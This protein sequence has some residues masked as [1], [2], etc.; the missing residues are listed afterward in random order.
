[1]VCSECKKHGKE[2][3]DHQKKSSK[4]CPYNEKNKKSLRSNT[5]LS[6]RINI[7][8]VDSIDKRKDF[9]LAILNV[10]NEIISDPSSL[11]K[12]DSKMNSFL[13]SQG[14]VSAQG[15]GNQVTSQEGSFALLLEKYNFIFIPKPKKNDHIS[16]IESN[17]IKDG[18]YYVYQFNGTQASIDFAIFLVINK[19]IIEQFEFDLKHTSTDIFYL[20]DGW[21]HKDIIYIVTWS[22]KNIVKSFIGLGQNIPT[23]VENNFMNELLKF[24]K[25]KNSETKKIGALYTYTRF[26]NRYSCKHFTEDYTNDNFNKV[27]TFIN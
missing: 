5:K 13:Q 26:A 1:M 24:K 20:N 15:T 9:R 22:S 7:N 16:Y 17:N 4:L 25:G 10:L 3:T 23:E 11:K 14:N 12:D 21:F 18:F 2:S 8:S 27:K 6:N 19:M